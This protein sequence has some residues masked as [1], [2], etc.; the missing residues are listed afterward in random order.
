MKIRISKGEWY[1]VY[2]HH[3]DD[4]DFTN[5]LVVVSKE[6]FQKWERIDKEFQEMQSELRQLY[7]SHERE[8]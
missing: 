3:E 2:S 5:I 7:Y 1:P 6:Q 8:E 4:G